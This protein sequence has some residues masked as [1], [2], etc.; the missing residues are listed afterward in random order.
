MS[1][2]ITN[3]NEASLPLVIRTEYI[4]KGE[5]EVH[6]IA[7]GVVKEGME[8]GPVKPDNIT[9]KVV[10][11]KESRPAKGNWTASV[12]TIPLLP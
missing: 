6:V 9:Y 2:L 7:D 1:S 11:I 12:I 3:P 10:S 4:S 8:F 5:S